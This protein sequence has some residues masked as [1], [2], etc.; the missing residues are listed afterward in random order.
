[1]IL[2]SVLIGKINTLIDPFFSRRTRKKQKQH[3]QTSIQYVRGKK[4]QVIVVSL[5]LSLF[6][7]FAIDGMLL[8]AYLFE[9]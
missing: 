4:Q 3:S 2:F 9:P 5:S 8:V 1:M 7:A 6:L